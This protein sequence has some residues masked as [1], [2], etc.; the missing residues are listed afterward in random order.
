MPHV[1]GYV[2]S[3]KGDLGGRA[4]NTDPYGLQQVAK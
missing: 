3:Q 1:H 4:D 2:T